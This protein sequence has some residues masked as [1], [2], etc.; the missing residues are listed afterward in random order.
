MAVNY[1]YY[2]FNILHSVHKNMAIKTGNK[3]EQFAS[4]IF[5]LMRSLRM[6]IRQSV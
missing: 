3:Y 1:Y 6:E 2:L 4:R 5:E